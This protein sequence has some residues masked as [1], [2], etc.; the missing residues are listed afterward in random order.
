MTEQE[1]HAV[2]WGRV[3]GVYFRQFVSEEARLLGLTG[4]VRNRED[5]Q[6]LELVARGSRSSL[7]VLLDSI[8]SCPPGAHVDRVDATWNTAVGAPST[9]F[10]ILE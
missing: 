4:W 1:V 10:E 3:Q 9:S 6:W 5:G 8:R 7:E 2:V